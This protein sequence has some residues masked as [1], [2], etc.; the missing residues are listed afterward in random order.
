[1]KKFTVALILASAAIVGVV[2]VTTLS[3]QPAKADARVG[4]DPSQM[5]ANAKNLPV[6]HYDDY[7]VV[8]N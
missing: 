6:A 7:S 2:A 8:F 4:I 1:M 5:M 3:D